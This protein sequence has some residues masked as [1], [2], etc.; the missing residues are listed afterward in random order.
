M[1]VIDKQK[2]GSVVYTGNVAK[3]AASVNRLASGPEK[4]FCAVAF[5]SRAMTQKR[6]PIPVVFADRL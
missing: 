5:L 1:A 4:T 6:R 2:S 3:N